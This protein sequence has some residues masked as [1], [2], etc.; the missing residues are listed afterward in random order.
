MAAAQTRQFAGAATHPADQDARARA[1]AP[2]TQDV[3]TEL[4]LFCARM[5][6]GGEQPDRRAWLGR[7][8]NGALVVALLPLVLPIA[9]LVA[10]AV[11]LDSPGPVI[12]RSRRV[13]LAGRPFELLK[14][15]T[16]VRDAQGPLISAAG[17]CRYTPLGAYLARSRLDELPQPLNILRGEMRFVGPRPELEEF[18]AANRADYELILSVLPGLTGPAQCRIRVGGEGPRIRARTRARAAL[19]RVSASCEGLDR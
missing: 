11:W 9:A 16:M 8:L 14:F 19:P 5:P 13:G 15:R 1:S 18:V 7:A 3:R 2:E 4:G 10:V 6:V 12:Y 17:D